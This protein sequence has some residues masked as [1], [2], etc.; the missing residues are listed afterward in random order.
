MP[1]KRQLLPAFGSTTSISAQCHGRQ[2][3]HQSHQNT[4]PAKKAKHVRLPDA[5]ANWTAGHQSAALLQ[6]TVWGVWGE[7]V[8][9]CLSSASI[10]LNYNAS[11]IV[12]IGKNNPNQRSMPLNYH[13]T[14]K[15]HMA[16]PG[17]RSCM[18]FSFLKNFFSWNC[19][20][21]NVSNISNVNNHYIT[22]TAHEN[23]FVV[24]LVKCF[25]SKGSRF[26]LWAGKKITFFLP[27]SCRM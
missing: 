6:A 26:R 20:P 15:Q 3:C 8:E 24:R 22:W 21:P 18:A 9:W 4:R 5:A 13:R 10:V 14:S 11:S 7:I 2:Q 1:Q 23:C 16:G 17:G 27:S 12:K 19:F 25:T